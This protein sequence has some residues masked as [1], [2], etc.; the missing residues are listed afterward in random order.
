MACSSQKAHKQQSKQSVHNVEQEF[1]EFSGGDS[2]DYL[3]TMESVSAVHM[4]DIFSSKKIKKCNSS[5]TVVQQSTSSQPMQTTLAMFNKSELKPLGCVKAETLNPKNEQSFLTEYTI[6]PESHTALLGAESVQQFGLITVNTDKN[7]S[8]SDAP[9]TPPDIASELENVFSGEGKL[10]EKL[11]LEI[12]KSVPPVVLPL[13]A[14][15]P[16][17]RHLRTSRCSN[18]LDFFIGGRQKK[19][20]K[21]KALYQ[22]EAPQSSTQEKPLTPSSD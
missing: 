10:E 19:Q 17:T 5:W 9:P 11:H 20:W 18:G 14:K 8:L 4:K 2:N 16:L 7:M 21:N 13:A 6:V 12:D 15:E 22:P 3:F 1:Q